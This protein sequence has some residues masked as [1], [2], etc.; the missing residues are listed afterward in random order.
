MTGIIL[1]LRHFNQDF[2]RD[3]PLSAIEI[4]PLHPPI[5][6]FYRVISNCYG[7]TRS[8]ANRKF[9][10]P[11][12]FSVNRI[13]SISIVPPFRIVY[14]GGHEITG[15]MCFPSPP[16]QIDFTRF[17]VLS[18]IYANL[19]ESRFYRPGDGGDGKRRDLTLVYLHNRVVSPFVS[20]EMRINS[21]S[22]SFLLSFV[23]T[24]DD[25]RRKCNVILLM[26]RSR[27]PAPGMRFTRLNNNK[28]WPKL[29][30]VFKEF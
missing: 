21:W 28:L 8:W 12:E 1:L 7:P 11:Q 15:T 27:A 3:C 6:R 29:N 4:N 30:F 16:P 13:A 9:R 14:R 10:L 19:C 5:A 26:H 24:L 2:E 20:R 22:W 18:I 23:S 17:A 25:C